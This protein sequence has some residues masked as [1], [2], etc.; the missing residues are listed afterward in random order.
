MS[1]HRSRFSLVIGDAETADAALSN[2]DI[3]RYAKRVRMALVARYGPDLGDELTAECMA[4]AWENAG[5]LADMD[6]PV[7][8]L[9]RVGQSKSRRFLRW[10]K[11]PVHFP[12][13]PATTEHAWSEPA[14]P[15]ALAA[16]GEEERTA[17]VLVHC[18]QWSYD[19]VAELLE[20][21]LHTVRNRI[22]R[23]LN[24]LRHDLGV[25]Q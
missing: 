21:P 2:D 12:A 17:V 7:G 20:L 19:E 3:E 9:V 25:N 22:H 11:K 23:G 1:D 10:R 13:R 16:L 8:Y 5:R 14:L 15:G 4:W 6:N 18:F 24:K